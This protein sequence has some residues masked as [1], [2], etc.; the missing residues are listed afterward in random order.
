MSFSHFLL[1]CLW[2]WWWWFKLLLFSTSCIISAGGSLAI[3]RLQF[4]DI[5][6]MGIRII[7]TVTTAPIV[8]AT[9][10]IISAIK[11]YWHS[12]KMIKGYFALWENVLLSF[13]IFVRGDFYY[14]IYSHFDRYLRQ[15]GYWRARFYS[16]KVQIWKNRGMLCE[17]K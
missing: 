6:R 16:Q 13:D 15:Y 17:I 2:W 14:K 10:G 7:T 3:S 1:L 9:I 11:D 4:I 8:I 12:F 5:Y